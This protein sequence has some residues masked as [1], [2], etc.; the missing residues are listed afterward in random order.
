MWG[1]RKSKS[2]GTTTQTPIGGAANKRA[3]H[4]HQRRPEFIEG[5]LFQFSI[6]RVVGTGNTKSAENQANQAVSGNHDEHTEKPPEDFPF[7][8]VTTGIGGLGGDE[9]KNT[10]E[11]HQESN[12]ES[13]QNQR[14]QYELIDFVEK[15]GDVHQASP[16]HL[17]TWNCWN[18][19]RA[20]SI[21]LESTGDEVHKAPDPDHYEKGD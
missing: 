21:N 6:K 11:E 7:A 3:V 10:P 16:I 9:L 1:L 12:A 17:E 13:K 18:V 8:L 4:E 19:H 2:T 15:L 5:R 20:T 14:V